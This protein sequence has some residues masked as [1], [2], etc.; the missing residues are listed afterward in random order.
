MQDWHS[1][2]L[3]QQQM[4]SSNCLCKRQGKDLQA[5]SNARTLLVL[6]VGNRHINTAACV[7]VYF[8]LAQL[9]MLGNLVP[10]SDRLSIR[11]KLTCI[12]LL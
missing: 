3:N 11:S 7:A 6:G 5:Q 12:F 4:V 2:Q 9:I 1:G 10:A 8:N